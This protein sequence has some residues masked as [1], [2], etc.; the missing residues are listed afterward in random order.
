L[1]EDVTVQVPI[2]GILL[3]KMSKIFHKSSIGSLNIVMIK[4]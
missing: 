1:R 2:K 3:G 4:N